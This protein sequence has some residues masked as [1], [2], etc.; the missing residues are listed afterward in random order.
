MKKLYKQEKMKEEMQFLF[1]KTKIR[2]G[3]SEFR[4]NKLKFL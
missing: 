1:T 2:S 3:G 4:N